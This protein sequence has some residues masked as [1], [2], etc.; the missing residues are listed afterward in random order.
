M[1]PSE[2]RTRN[3]RRRRIGSPLSLAS[4]MPLTMTVPTVITAK[5]PRMG[6]QAP[7]AT[8]PQIAAPA[9]RPIV[10]ITPMRRVRLLLARISFHNR[11]S[12]SESMELIFFPSFLC[13]GSARR[14]CIG[15]SD[16][17]VIFRGHG[18]ISDGVVTLECSVGWKPGVEALIGLR[19]VCFA[20][21][22]K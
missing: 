14:V 10:A 16:H 17:Q 8:P 12:S 20:L 15:G 2:T 4:L 11:F 1:T 21:G 22:G 9:V 13:A 18:E 6:S 7:V 5:N 3:A 19:L